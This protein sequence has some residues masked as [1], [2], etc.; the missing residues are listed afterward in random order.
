MKLVTTHALFHLEKCIGCKTC[1]H[2]C[3]TGAYVPSPQ[4][5][6]EKQKVAP[7]SRG[8][9]MGSDVEGFLFLVSQKRYE[10]AYSLLLQTNPL[11]GITGRVCHHPCEAQCNRARY[12]DRV[13]IQALERFVSDQARTKG[14][15]PPIPK[16]T[17][18]ARVAVIGAGP[19]G[20]SCAYHLGR[21][22]YRVTLYE[23]E[24]RLGGMLAYGI[25]GYRLPK[26]VLEWEIQNILSCNV[27]VR[28]GRA[29]G[30]NL[31]FGDLRPFDAIFLATGAWKER[32]V[33]LF[34]KKGGALLSALEFLKGVNSNRPMALGPRVAVIG[35]GNAAVDAARCARRLGSEVQI[36][37]RRSLADMPAL[38]S[39]RESAEK[40]GVQILPHVLPKRVLVE[41]GKIVA[42][43]CVKTSPGEAGP[44]G[45]KL[46]LAMKGT[47]FTIPVD[48]V[49]VAA[50]ETP[51]LSAFPSSIKTREGRLFIDEHGAT[52]RPFTFA[53][54]DLA[55]EAGTVSEAI[56]SGKRAAMA[57]DRAVRG[58]SWGE[59][60]P[61]LPIV[62]F[63]EL[64]P[65]YFTS[66]PKLSLQSLR[67][68]EAVLSFEEVWKGCDEKEA[69]Q[70]AR[71]CFGCA[72]PPV[73]HTEDCRG[74]SNCVDR[75]P[76]SAITLEL[77]EPPFEVRVD[78]D[79][80]SAKEIESLCLKAKLHPQQIVCYCTNTTAGEIAAAILKG[81]R[82]PEAVSRMTGARTGCT[83]LCVQSIV[84]LLEA[85]GERIEPKETHPCYGLTFTLWDVPP[86]IR[87]KYK[88]G[89]YHFE[90]DEALIEK[91]LKMD[92][93]R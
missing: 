44:D 59:K 81:A 14:Y 56:A 51:D 1:T 25:P 73:Y 54:G 37:Y 40:E 43:E 27:E 49:I 18:K 6:L 83:V 89:G 61:E 50:G 88:P 4:R 21:M 19:A 87:E 74:C 75:C 2:V 9:P 64:N 86:E 82:T 57:M 28:L 34:R 12:D 36:L 69:L 35:G 91:I 66:A 85:S 32:S 8:C 78:T 16:V 48:T 72:A 76:S 29:L 79:D 65:D 53:G 31:K 52:T 5:P 26:Q 30:K 71:R 10:E 3:P 17:T 33:P 45:R 13:S 11:P 63:E 92:S 22:G 23:A 80:L 38:L 46:P 67:P 77:C 60:R 93:Q 84:K 24:K 58:E 39:E 15:R 70:E 42:V 62:L 20:L 47:E 7:C 68:E 55:S 90:E 41:K